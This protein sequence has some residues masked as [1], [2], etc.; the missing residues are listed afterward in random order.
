M[1]NTRQLE[2]FKIHQ[3]YYNSVKDPVQMPLWQDYTCLMQLED[4]IPLLFQ[5]LFEP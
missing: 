5:S 2:A 4:F 1:V 3:E